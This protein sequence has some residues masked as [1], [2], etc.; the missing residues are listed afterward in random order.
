MDDRVGEER[1]YQVSRGKHSRRAFGRGWTIAAATVAALLLLGGGTAYA[2]YHYDLVSASRILP[3]VSIAGVEVGNLT[4]DEAVRAVTARADTTLA[5]T[6]TVSAAGHTW[7]VTPASLGTRADI[8]GAVDRAFAVADSMSMLSR[9]YHR[10]A[11]KAVPTSIELRFTYDRAKLRAFVDQVFDE[12]E[13]PAVDAS[14][15]LV[16]DQLVLQHA[17]AGRELKRGVALRRLETALRQRLSTVTLPVQTVEPSVT[18]ATLGKTIV[19]DL[20]ENMLYLYDGLK[21]IKQYP[22]ATAAPGYVTPVGT[23]SVVNKVENPTWYN[24][25]PDGWGAGEP[26]V[27]PPGPGNP[28]GTRALYLNAPGIRIHGTYASSSIGTHASHG[29]IRMYI[30]D[31]EELYPLVPIGTK[32]IIKP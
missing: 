18:P 29:C 20:S 22:V 7:T 3:G 26:L 17:R 25:A 23:W 27:I 12:V 19:V 24:P 13:K 16:N 28:L 21:V 32:V 14:I 15:T 8:E 31:S 5:S 11:D 4:R 30:S 6:L 10:V 2:A 1:R 9:V